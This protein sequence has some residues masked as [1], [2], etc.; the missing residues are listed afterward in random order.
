MRL[1][2]KEGKEAALTCLSLSQQRHRVDVQVEDANLARL[3][4]RLD[5]GEGGAVV[6]LL[7]L[8]VLHKAAWW[9]LVGKKER[10]KRVSIKDMLT[11][12][13][14]TTRGRRTVP[15]FL[16]VMLKHLPGDEVVVDAV[17]FAVLA[18]P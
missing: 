14:T 4:D 12:T 6:V 3:D 8:A 7:V 5:G 10:K 16:D 11:A 9:G 2:K 13:T 18:R 15:T 17:E 1:K